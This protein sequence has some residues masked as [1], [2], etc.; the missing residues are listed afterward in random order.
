MPQ[1]L[2]G[3]AK[4]RVVC[5]ES[6]GPPNGPLLSRV[7]ATR[8]GVTGTKR[9]AVG[10]VTEVPACVTV[11][12]WPPMV[13]VPVRAELPL[14]TSTWN[15]TVPLPVPFAPAVT[16]SHEALLIAVQVQPAGAVTVTLPSSAAGRKPA[17]VAERA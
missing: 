3:I 15:E 2:C 9:K 17:V 10:D 8:Q 13:S 16:V 4:S 1:A 6:S 14:L 7:S 12:V 11:M 5:P